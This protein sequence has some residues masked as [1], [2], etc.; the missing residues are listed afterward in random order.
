MSRVENH[1][2]ATASHSGEPRSGNEMHSSARSG[3]SASGTPDRVRYAGSCQVRR[4]ASGAPARAQGLAHDLG[5][6]R[7][8]DPGALW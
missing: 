6:H 3:R 4:I 5:E 8:G 1:S 7:S 2:R